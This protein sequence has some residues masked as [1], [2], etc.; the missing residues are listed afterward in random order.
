MPAE[1]QQSLLGR[2]CGRNWVRNQKGRRERS[3]PPSHGVALSPFRVCHLSQTSLETL[4][5]IRGVFA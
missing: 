4:I 2:F 1:T 3:W 5:E